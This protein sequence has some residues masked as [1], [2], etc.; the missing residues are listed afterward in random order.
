MQHVSE[1]QGKQCLDYVIDKYPYLQRYFPLFK[2]NDEFGAPITHTYGKYGVFSPTNL[3]YIKVAGDITHYFDDLNGK[4]IIEIGGGYG[5][6]CKV[7]SDLY[8]L[9]E[10]ILVDL[11]EALALAKR[12][13]HELG[14]KNVTLLTPEE[15][16]EGDVYDLV[17]S[18]YAFSECTRPVQQE[19]L[20]KIIARATRGYLIC[21]QIFGCLN[22]PPLS[23]RELTCELEKIHRVPCLLP[24]IPCTAQGNFLVVWNEENY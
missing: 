17:I 1:T 24:E 7:L 15:V 2:E 14:V 6:Q 3:R 9:K 12:N 4:R 5:G 23:P 16:K 22:T 21:N 11:P 10:Y 20:E 8:D 18:N 19:Y 13:L